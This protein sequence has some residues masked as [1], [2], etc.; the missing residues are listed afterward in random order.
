M[1]RKDNTG[2][3]FKIA[4]KESDKHPDLT[5]KCMVNGKEMEIAVWEN[6]SK[7]GSLYLSLKFQEPYVK[8]TVDNTN[9]SSDEI[10]F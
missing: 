1:E 6:T 7:K 5:G 4:E 9:A 3:L 2:V 10:P 8:Q